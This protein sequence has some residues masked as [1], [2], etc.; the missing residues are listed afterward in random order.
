MYSL[1]GEKIQPSLLISDKGRNLLLMNW[2]IIIIVGLGSQYPSEANEARRR[3]EQSW[4]YGR[5]FQEQ[6]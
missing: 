2:P 5:L 6:V 3:F 1:Q 4:K